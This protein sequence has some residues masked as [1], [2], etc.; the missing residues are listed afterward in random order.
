LAIVIAIM[1][2]DVFL[3]VVALVSLELQMRTRRKWRLTVSSQ[4]TL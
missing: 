2:I 4:D 1:K 3:R